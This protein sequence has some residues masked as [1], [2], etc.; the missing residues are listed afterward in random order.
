V[1]L[2]AR[3]PECD[4][5]LSLLKSANRLFMASVGYVEARSALGAL[6]RDGRLRGARS[7][8]ARLELERVW[9]DLN[10]VQLDDNLVRLSGDTAERLRLRAGDVIHLSS[11]LVLA[12]PDL[13]LATWD[14]DLGRAAR[15]AGLA[16]AP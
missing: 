6:T 15:E 11:A 2:L 8:Q 12:D 10:V 1:K 14:H 4:V 3:E 5:V 13:V 16:V 7:D 9:R